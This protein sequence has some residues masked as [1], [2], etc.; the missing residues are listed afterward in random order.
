MF[1]SLLYLETH[2]Q[3]FGFNIKGTVMS[4]GVMQPIMGRLYPPLQ[5]VSFVDKEGAAY[6]GGVRIG[7]RI[8]SVN[9]SDVMGSSHKQVVD[10]VLRGGDNLTL[11]VLRVDEKEAVSRRSLPNNLIAW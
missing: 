7:D 9:D 11:R 3:G 2:L 10:H 8:L 4:G 5:Y 1:P 6:E